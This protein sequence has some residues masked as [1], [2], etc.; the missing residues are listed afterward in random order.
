M[1][2]LLRATD[3]SRELPVRVG[4]NDGKQAITTNVASGAGTGIGSDMF[5][6]EI[7]LTYIKTLGAIM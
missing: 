1:I 4:I 7:E 2:S 5:T 3:K 6:A